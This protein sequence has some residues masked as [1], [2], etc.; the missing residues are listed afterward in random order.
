MKTADGHGLSEA[1]T[2]QIAGLVG[3]VL[4]GAASIMEL[5]RMATLKI[6]WP[7]FVSKLD[8][9]LG[10]IAIVFWI[11][12]AWVLARRSRK[13]RVLAMAGAFALFSYGLLGT[14]AGSHF[15]IVYVAFGLIMPLIERLA[16]GGK[17]PLGRREGEPVRTSTGREV[18]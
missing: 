8:W 11:G 15:G 7:G 10:A 13:H 18:I 3:A 1:A 14:I 2:R 17:L 9:A 16:F 5:I 6:P 12:S 4:F